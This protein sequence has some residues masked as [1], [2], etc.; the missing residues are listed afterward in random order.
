[1]HTKVNS[2]TDPFNYKS[3]N[4]FFFFFFLGGGGGGW[5]WGEAKP[6][7]K[8]Q[9]YLPHMTSETYILMYQKVIFCVELIGPPQSFT[10]SLKNSLF[11]LID[12]IL[13]HDYKQTNKSLLYL[14]VITAWEHFSESVCALDLYWDVW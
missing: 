9:V 14:I 6:R 2:Y 7:T 8:Y 4:F 1:M 10:A 3:W 5:G 12:G 13:S 11:W